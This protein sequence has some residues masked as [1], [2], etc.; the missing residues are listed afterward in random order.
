MP[1]TQSLLNYTSGLRA[2]AA[3]VI[4]ILHIEP[5]LQ[6]FPSPVPIC[7]DYEHGLRHQPF[8]FSMDKT[9]LRYVMGIF[10]TLVGFF[11][12]KEIL[13]TPPSI[14]AYLKY[15]VKRYLRLWLPALPIIIQWEWAKMAG[16]E[17]NFP[18][19]DDYSAFHH[20]LL[21]S[22]F[23]SF[24][25]VPAG[26][27]WSL[28]S[29]TLCAVVLPLFLWGC[30]FLTKTMGGLMSR[31]GLMVA[32]PILFAPVIG[33]FF[34]SFRMH[35]PH[36]FSEEGELDILTSTAIYSFGPVKFLGYVFGACL[37]CYLGRNLVAEDEEE[38]EVAEE[39][40]E[41]CIEPE[42]TNT[43]LRV[44]VSVLYDMVAIGL[45]ALSKFISVSFCREA[46]VEIDQDMR[47][48]DVFFGRTVASIVLVAGFVMPMVK[49]EEMG[50]F[51]FDFISGGLFRFLGK[52]SFSIFLA[53]YPVYEWVWIR[54]GLLEK[55]FNGKIKTWLSFRN[56]YGFHIGRIAMVG[57]VI[58][59]AIIY[60]YCYTGLISKFV[61]NMTLKKFNFVLVMGLLV[62]LGY[63]LVFLQ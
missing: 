49:P 23:V 26:F 12:A 33:M 37:F 54:S 63:T 18:V 41:E 38:E 42:K 52:I 47:M 30:Q 59:A 57:S 31:R 61:K 27:L 35:S 3:I 7:D 62:Y 34:L 10:H 21:R 6:A 56:L 45:I 25:L 51:L 36:L 2:I 58:F 9:A 22:T 46:M 48:F 15:V 16:I 28:A 50:N 17:Y 39:K 14:K 1:K 13:S 20:L 60:H 4:A 40:K 19:S 8:P 24:Y 29:D 5:C 53:Q 43:G 44:M 32:A 55:L 11:C